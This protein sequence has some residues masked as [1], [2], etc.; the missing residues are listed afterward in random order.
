MTA[1][2]LLKLFLNVFFF[3]IKITY[4]TLLHRLLGM[5]MIYDSPNAKRTV[6]FEY[7]NRQLVWHGF[8]VNKKKLLFFNCFIGI[9]NVFLAVSKCTKN[10]ELYI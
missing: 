3:L 5:R 2:I 7:M 4:V 6:S 9:F 1:N 10:K 8:T